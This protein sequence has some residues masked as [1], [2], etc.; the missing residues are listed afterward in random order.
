VKAAIRPMTPFKV[1]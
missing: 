1:I